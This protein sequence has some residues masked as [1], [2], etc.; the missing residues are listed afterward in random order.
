[1]RIAFQKVKI[2]FQDCADLNQALA[3]AS[4]AAKKGD[5]VILSPGGTSFGQFKNEFDRGE[6]F[7]KAVSILAKK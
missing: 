6:K 1:M 2:G 7:R 4:R 3:E 5:A